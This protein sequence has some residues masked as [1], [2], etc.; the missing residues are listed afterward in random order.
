MVAKQMVLPAIESDD[1]YSNGEFPRRNPGIRNPSS[2]PASRIS[3]SPVDSARFL[4]SVASQQGY[5]AVAPVARA[6]TIVVVA[7]STSMTEHNEPSQSES[8]SN[9][10]VSTTSIF[11]NDQPGRFLTAETDDNYSILSEI[12]DVD[13]FN[14]IA[15]IYFCKL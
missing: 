1:R 9:L 5:M 12:A 14:M 13:C 11:I 6:T 2:S 10:G 15:S 3:L 8:G 4:A 7:L